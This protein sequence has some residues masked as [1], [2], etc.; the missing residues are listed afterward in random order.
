MHIVVAS[1]SSSVC[2][3][4]RLTREVFEN[5]RFIATS[6]KMEERNVSSRT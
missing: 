4:M 2:V 5:I 6:D 3:W 1:K